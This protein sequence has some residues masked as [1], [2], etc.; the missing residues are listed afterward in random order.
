MILL[1]R[2]NVLNRLK[3]T[4]NNKIE[5]KLNQNKMIFEKTQFQ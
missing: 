5:S 4:K 1:K 3:N 2:K